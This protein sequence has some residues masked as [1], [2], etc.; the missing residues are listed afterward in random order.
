MREERLN[1]R[2]RFA[3]QLFLAYME[4][5]FPKDLLESVIESEFGRR[6]RR[7]EMDFEDTIQS[8][9]EKNASSQLHKQWDEIMTDKYGGNKNDDGNSASRENGDTEV[10]EAV[11]I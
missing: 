4:G 10:R 1:P 5:I 7:G 2:L 9:L 6:P 11:V 8:T 3:A